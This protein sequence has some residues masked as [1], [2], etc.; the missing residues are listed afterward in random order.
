M[1]FSLYV[2]IPFCR[3]KCDYCDFFSVPSAK[4]CLLPDKN[5]VDAVLAECSFL[6]Q[7]Y[8]VTRWKT[9]YIGGGTPSQ[10]GS[11]LLCLLVEGIKKAVKE[12][13]IDE[14]TVEMNPEDITFELLEA[15]QRCGID[16][17]SMGIQALDDKALGAINRHCS[18]SKVYSA[19]ELVEKFWEKKL[20]VDFISGLPCQT[21]DSFKNQFQQI[22]K[23][24]KID[25]ISL[26]TLTVEE[27]TPL[28]KKIE[29]GKIK[30][31]PEKADKM[32]IIGR[33][34]LEK[35]G[36]YQ[37][38]ISNFSK[39]GFKS[40]HN[41]TY[42]HLDSYL[43]CG[44]GACSSV[45][46]KKTRRWTNTVSIKKYEDFWL[47]FKAENIQKL[48][49]IQNVELISRETEIFEWLMMGFRLVDG[50]CEEDFKKRFNLELEERIG[51]KNGVFADW[52]KRKLAKTSVK[53]EKTYYS[54]TKRGI[55]LLN[56]FLE[57]LL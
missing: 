7:K 55:M 19:L 40:L 5:Y 42:W 24:K 26:Y 50:V 17:I 27:N 45:Y 35:N 48:S 6:V 38:E 49:E 10:L 15:A 41:Q 31:N 51:T 36:F 46:E 9:V 44:A 32:W 1:D 20:S 21:Y 33:N 22:F 56:Q 14:F 53:N 8:S 39:P 34:L 11:E 25:H 16:R 23:Y 47:N 52:K 57:S 3:Q 29:S 28:Y 37:Y 18:V 12:K 30:W 2:H 13:K 4:S 43:G 54:L